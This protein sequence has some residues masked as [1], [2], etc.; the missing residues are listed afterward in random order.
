MQ[1]TIDPLNRF[2]SRV[3]NYVKYR[4][5]YPPELMSYIRDIL[6]SESPRRVVDVGAGTGIFSKLLLSLGYEVTAV[7]P[8]EAMRIAAEKDLNSYSNYRSLAAAAED[9]G[10]PSNSFDAVFAAQAFHWFDAQKAHFE[11]SRILK[12]RG[13]VGLIWNNREMESGF[14]KAYENFLGEFGTDYASV[15]AHGI[16][17]EKNM[18]EFFKP[19]G[20]TLKKFENLQSFDWESLWGRFLSCSYAPKEGHELHLP[21]EKK[22]KEIFTKYQVNE[23]IEMVYESEIFWSYFKA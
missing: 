6:Q 5:T 7:E 22:L 3:E 23:K 16:V 20:Y 17:A 12:P 13:I 4:P 15:R 2:T 1:N 8:N 11:F 21:A 10:L 18:H 19:Q 9:T 14:G